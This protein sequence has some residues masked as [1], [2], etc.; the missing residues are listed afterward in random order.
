MCRRIPANGSIF[1]RAVFIPITLTEKLAAVP[2]GLSPCR[3][4]YLDP[5]GR[6]AGAVDT[7]PVLGDHALQPTRAA[8]L[9]QTAAVLESLGVEQLGNAGALDQVSKS[10]LAVLELDRAQIVAVVVHEI[11]GPQYQVVF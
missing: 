5:R 2:I 11:E 4:L 10:A 8:F 1:D 6:T 9:K 3:A 7:I